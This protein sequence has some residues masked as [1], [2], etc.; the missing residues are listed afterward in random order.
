MRKFA[1][2]GA[3]ALVAF[4]CTTAQAGVITN[5][6]DWQNAVGT[7]ETENFNDTTLN[8]GITLTTD[9]GIVDGALYPDK[10]YDN[11]VDENDSTTWSFLTPIGAWGGT[12][13]LDGPGGP[14]SS[15]NVYRGNALVFTGN[16]PNSLAGTF[17]GFASG[18]L[19]DRVVLKEG[20]GT[21]QERYT[22]DNMVYSTTVVPLPPAAWLGLGLLG[23]LGLMRR[24]RRRREV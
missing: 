20:P 8:T 15:I 21:F 22:M 3:L 17:W 24:M 10:F 1:L 9:N 11:L 5:E 6:T 23:S 19:F 2:A 12:F 4:A 18:A 14:G 16:I 13:D 7:W